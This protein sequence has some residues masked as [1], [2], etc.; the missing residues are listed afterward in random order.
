MFSQKTVTEEEILLKELNSSFFLLKEPFQVTGEYKLKDPLEIKVKEKKLTLPL[1]LFNKEKEVEELVKE[2]EQAPFGIGKETVYDTNVRLALHAK[3]ENFS[4]S[5]KLEETDILEKVRKLLAPQTSKI[6][7]EFSKF[8][9]YKKGGFF[10][11]HRDTP[12]STEM[13]G[14]LVLCLP[15]AF[16]GGRFYIL[17]NEQKKE[18]FWDQD[19]TNFSEYEL[20]G[21]REEIK[22][23]EEEEKKPKSKK[24]SYSWG[25]SYYKT[26]SFKKMTPENVIHWV[27]FYGDC[28]H[29]IL[30]VDYGYRMT[31]TYNL[32]REKEEDIDLSKLMIQRTN[33]FQDTLEKCLKSDQ[34]MSK[35]GNLGF[36][37]WHFY[38]DEELL[39]DKPNNY[40]K[41]TNKVSDLMLKGNDAIVAAS[42]LAL[43][44]NVFPLRVLSEMCADQVYSLKTYP[45]KLKNKITDDDLFKLKGRVNPEKITWCVQIHQHN[46]EKGDQAPCKKFQEVLHSSTGYFGNEGGETVFYTQ[47]VLVIEV[48]P[49]DKR[50]ELSKISSVD[51]SNLK[52]EKSTLPKETKEKPKRKREEGSEKWPKIP[53]LKEKLKNLGLK[54]SGTKDELIERLQENGVTPKDL[55]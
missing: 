23:K 4:C 34:F 14:T 30:P 8:N 3:P 50:K 27:A 5:F 48:P 45:K 40:Y 55:Q 38:E 51:I 29:E 11:K 16:A 42:A 44:L 25:S 39:E 1:D 22:R 37:A 19:I 49:F 35:G 41:K 20:K 43:S 6:T 9:V 52:D 46:C 21:L 24:S 12:R 15:L 13:F 53:I 10:K 17:H 32:Y 2:C 31:L 7:A 54:V 47:T 33:L 18:L 36:A 28:E 26:E